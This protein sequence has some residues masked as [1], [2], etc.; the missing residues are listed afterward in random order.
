M[1]HFFIIYIIV[2][3]LLCHYITFTFLEVTQVAENQVLALQRHVPITK[4]ASTSWTIA[5][6]RLNGS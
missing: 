4:A 3:Y 1:Y 2:Y 5:W 6:T